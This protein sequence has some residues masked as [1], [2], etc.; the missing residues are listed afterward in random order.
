[1]K[2]AETAS[3]LPSSPGVYLMKDKTGR[4]LYIGKAKN[5]KS[6]VRNYLRPG[7]D[8]RAH[9][10]FMMERA[11]S[12][13]WVVTGSEK[14]ALILEN[15]LIK[16]HRPRYN[17]DLKDDKTYLSL[18]LGLDEDFPRLDLVRRVKRDKAFYLGPYSSARD[19]R[20]TVE[21][22]LKIF[23]LR[24]CNDRD[25][26][27]R[28]RPCLYHWTRGCPA[29]C[30]GLID[31]EGYGKLVDE[32]VAFFRGKS[33]GLVERLLDKMEEAAKAERFEE[34]ALLRD[35]LRA[36]EATLE[37][38]KI[39][40]HT[41]VDRDAIGW[42]REGSEV[43]VS[44]FVVRGGAVIDERSYHLASVMEENEEF[45]AEFL[46]SYYREDRIVPPVVLV[47]SG[48][49]EG[50]SAL[51]AW[52]AERRGRRVR[53]LSPQRGD[54]AALLRMAG[55][56][57]AAKLAERRKSKIGF[58]TALKELGAKLGLPGPPD[59]IECFDIS[60]IQGTNPVAGMVTFTGGQ[61]DKSRYRRF[62]I[63][64][65]EGSDDFAM[66][67]EALKRRIARRNEEGWELPDLIVIDGGR[68]QLSSA[69]RAF[70]DLG[71]EPPAMIGLAKARSLKGTDEPEK[72]P[73]RVFLPGRANPLILRQNSSALF[74]LQRI[75]DEAHR[76]S[77]AFHRQKRSKSTITTELDSIPGMGP[78]RRKAL[79]TAFGSL[80]GVKSATL[81]ELTAV[82]GVPRQLAEAVHKKFNP[83]RG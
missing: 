4:I 36:V 30:R 28:E 21:M 79:L 12:L 25:F 23:P 16:K 71:V 55:E 27:T 57:A 56:N 68:G 74:M 31:R 63:K 77:V 45:A 64:T 52:L 61:P 14:E 2:I 70:S 19:L 5:L 32:V 49:G 42:V 11:E 80:K 73:E 62:S 53:I 60:N 43:Q 81:E 82:E 41:P 78:A 29:P 18:R 58:E 33:M 37:K 20:A 39:V 69:M 6:R 7:A 35:R 59:A 15:N 65:V 13:E 8:G 48:V 67:H 10:V 83:T 1:M 3:R 9:I 40:T 26:R 76:F 72:S 22:L 34:A 66:L 47:Q 51:E 44:V 17:V 50:H 75:R 54:K 24:S 46:R 38:Q